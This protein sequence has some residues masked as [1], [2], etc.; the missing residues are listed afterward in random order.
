MNDTQLKQILSTMARVAVVGMSPNPERASHGISRWLIG[1]GVDVVGV[2]PGHT[3][4]LDRPVYPSLADVPGR[5]DVVDIFRRGET[6]GPIVDAAVE[7]GDGM[8]WMQEN[9]ENEDAAAIAREAGVPVI[10]DRCIYK[11]WLRLLNG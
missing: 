7:R 6:V 3:R 11:E 1:L 5:V 8:V 4:L 2:N 9:V 10:M